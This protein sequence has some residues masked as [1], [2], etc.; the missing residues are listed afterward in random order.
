MIGSPPSVEI[1]QSLLAQRLLIALESTSTQRWLIAQS[2]LVQ[3]GYLLT[4]LQWVLVAL[5]QL[6]R[7]QLVNFNH[8]LFH[9]AL[10]G[11]LWWVCFSHFCRV[12]IVQKIIKLKWSYLR[13]IR[14]YITS[15]KRQAAMNMYCSKLVIRVLML[16]RRR[17]LRAQ[18]RILHAISLLLHTRLT[19]ST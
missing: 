15:T 19:L 2:L 10:N 11:T 12:Q 6:Y 4:T 3:T 17:D 16:K 18:M 8:Q 13:P 1:V 7:G 14:H 9:S 5:R